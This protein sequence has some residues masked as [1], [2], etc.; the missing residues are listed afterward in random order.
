MNFNEYQELSKRTANPH[1][2][3]I[4]NYGMGLA[5]ETGELIDMFKKSIFHGHT[6]KQMQ[7]LK[8]SGDVLWYTSQLSR[9]FN[10]RMDDAFERVNDQ[11][12]GLD[13]KEK[14]TNEL[15]MTSCINLSNTVGMINGHIDS[16]RYT[17]QQL[18]GLF[19]NIIR[20]LY[21]LGAVINLTLEE[22]AEANINKLKKRYPDGFSQEASINRED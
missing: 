3:E 9:L 21:F 7:V 5:G 10:I 22:T 2:N 18:E 15:I 8:E 17:K 1:D 12:R 4:Y 19:A 14:H 13:I 20:N 11:F 6:L 16:E